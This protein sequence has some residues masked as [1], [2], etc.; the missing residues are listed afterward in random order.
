MFL[1]IAH[2]VYDL[3]EFEGLGETDAV[4]NLSRPGLQ[5]IF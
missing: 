4:H 1:S 5:Q 3:N 2:I